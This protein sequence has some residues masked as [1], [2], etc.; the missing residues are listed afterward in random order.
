MTT[1]ALLSPVRL[2][3]KTIGGAVLTTAGTG[4]VLSS[5]KIASWVEPTQNI[6]KAFTGGEMIAKVVEGDDDKPNKNK[7]N[8]N[9]PDKTLPEGFKE[10]G[11]F[12]AGAVLGGG[13]VNLLDKDKDIPTPKTPNIPS[14][15]PDKPE[16]IN[17]EKEVG[18]SGETPLTPETT[19]IQTG[20]RRYK[21]RSKKITPSVR[22]SVR[23]NIVNTNQNKRYIKNT[24]Y[25]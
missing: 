22:Q 15:L 17:K 1:G 2:I 21:R 12:G 8:K 3:P 9:K 7:P 10:G 20:K 23:V 11:I 24:L 14:L 19:S 16:I 6:M 5:P 4:A 18:I 25:C 13:L